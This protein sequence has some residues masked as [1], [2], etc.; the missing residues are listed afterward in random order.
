M[1][2]R[3]QSPPAFSMGKEGR[4]HQVRKDRDLANVGPFSYTR[5]FAD[6]KSEPVFSMGKK[7]ESSLDSKTMNVPAPVAYQPNQ[8]QTKFKYPEFKFGSAKR[9]TSYDA[10]KAALVPAPGT[11]ELKSVAFAGLEKPRFHMGTRIDFDDTKK[12][13][14]SVPGPGAHDPAFR[15]TKSKSP[16]YSMGATLTSQ[17]DTTYLVPGP[18]S[19]VNSAEKLK[20]SSP[21]FGFGSSKRPALGATKMQV[22]GPGAYK[23]PAKIGDVPDFAMPNRKD[24]SKYV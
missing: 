15:P 2:N 22:P 19:Y 5:N 10:R 17:K 3:D 12:Y 23:L 4:G 13:I 14:H 7:L 20:C 6:K 21:S 18:G 8:S 16:V 11:Y 9:G 24:G 1:L